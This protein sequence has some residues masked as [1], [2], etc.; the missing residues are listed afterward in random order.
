MKNFVQCFEE[1]HSKTAP[2]YYMLLSS[3]LYAT[4]TLL[5]KQIPRVPME[6]LVFIEAIVMLSLN[7]TIVSQFK[8][9]IYKS[10]TLLTTKLILRGVLGCISTM[11]F[12]S[13]LK[14]LTVSE[15]IVL[16]RTSLVWTTIIAIVYLKNEKFEYGLVVNIVICLLGITLIAQPPFLT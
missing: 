1:N 3:F 15:G 11:L 8:M 9:E 12:Y 13:S 14:Y 7:Q 5:S 2:I 16:Y 4:S 10:S 6:Q